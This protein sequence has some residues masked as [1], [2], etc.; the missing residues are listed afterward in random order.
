MWYIIVYL[1]SLGGLLYNI[2]FEE[3]IVNYVVFWIWIL[4]MFCMYKL[5]GWIVN[6]IYW[7]VISD[8]EI[9][10][11]NIGI[12]IMVFFFYLFKS[13]GKYGVIYII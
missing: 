5:S 3:G 6:V 10:V 13:F 8:K 7:L 12:L 4:F 2:D 1:C 11:I 9:D